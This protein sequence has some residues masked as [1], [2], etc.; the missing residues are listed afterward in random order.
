MCFVRC[1][2]IN[3]SAID[4]KQLSIVFWKAQYVEL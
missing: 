1:L 4:F 3:K 2:N